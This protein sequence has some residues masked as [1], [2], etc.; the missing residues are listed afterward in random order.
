MITGAEIRR[1]RV[2][3]GLTRE[4]LAAHCSLQSFALMAVEGKDG[5]G[6]L[7][8]KQASRLLDAIGLDWED[9]FDRRAKTESAK[10]DVRM[11]GALIETTLPIGISEPDA[12]RALGWTRTRTARALAALRTNLGACGMSLA[13]SGNGRLRALVADGLVIEDLVD[14]LASDRAVAP[15]TD[16]EIL[17]LL[18]V[19][20]AVERDR[21]ILVDDLSGGNKLD[22]ARLLSVGYLEL[23]RERLILSEHAECSL[24]PLTALLRDGSLAS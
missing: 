11:L 14:E 12:S 19:M 6:D 24:A 9:A 7:S 13:V 5:I 18:S 15:I 20:A 16:R 22:A 17:F 4:E 1:R 2:E 8:T 10:S 3:S 23:D 21:A